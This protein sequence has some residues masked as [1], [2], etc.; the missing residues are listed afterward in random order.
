[1]CPFAEKFDDRGLSFKTYTT[2][3]VVNLVPVEPARGCGKN[4]IVL[5]FDQ[6]CSLNG[7]RLVALGL[8]FG[9]ELKIMASDVQDPSGSSILNWYGKTS[10]GGNQADVTHR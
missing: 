5:P 9:N 1:V 10:L 7:F 3:E 8:V 4:V 2:H 6:V